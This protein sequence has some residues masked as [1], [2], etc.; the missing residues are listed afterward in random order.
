[1]K[2][3]DLKK[4]VPL[5]SITEIDPAKRYLV[6]L[7]PSTPMNVAEIIFK[8]LHEANLNCLIMMGDDIKIY[9]MGELKVL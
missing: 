1:M 4:V 5:S 7:P 8:Q 6:R 2:V 9:D 3:S